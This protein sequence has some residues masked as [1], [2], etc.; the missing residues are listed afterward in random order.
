MRRIDVFNGDADGLC[1]LRQLRLA[2]PGPT[3]LVTGVKRDI[4][5]LARVQA[6]DGDLVTVLDVSLERNRAALLGLLERGVRV[7]YFDHHF[8]GDVPSH[9]RL[10]ASI[11]ASP[12][13]CTSILVDRHLGGRYRGWA[14]AAAFGDGLDQAAVDLG[15]TMPLGAAELEKLRELGRSLNYN[16]YGETEADLLVP[17]ARLY[18]VLA[19]YED[20]LQFVAA[21]GLYDRLNKGRREDLE[22]AAGVA[23]HW[24][25]PGGLV[26]VLPAAAWSRRVIGTLASHLA[27]VHRRQAIAVLAPRGEAYVVSLRVPAGARRGADEFCREY[28]GGGGRKEAAGI[29]LLPAG[30]LEAFV[31]RFS[32]LYR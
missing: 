10:E 8:A 21:K 28:P 9:P 23:P 12:G 15:A 26:L 1:A 17:P 31:K 2:D 20:P 5:L 4:A 32:S 7:R 16:A 13:V 25:G 22:A 11:D 14:V 18:R 29:N 24:S 3:E 19:R 27:G 6:G 30:E